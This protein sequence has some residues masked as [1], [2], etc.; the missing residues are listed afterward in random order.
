MFKDKVILDKP[1]FIGQAVLDYSK[2]EMYNLYYNIFRKCPLIR[3]PELVGGDT[4]SFF[5]A[6]HCH[7]NISLSDI[8]LSLRQFFDSSNYPSDHPLYSISN[9]AVLGCFKDEAAGKCI[10]EMILLRPKMYSMKYLGED[11]GIKRAKGISRH[12]VKSTSHQAY[13][14]A[15]HN[16]TE[17]S[18]NMTIIRSKLHTV[19]TVTF[20]KRGLSAWEDKRCWQDANSSVPHGSHLSGL[21]PKR[22]RVFLTPASGDV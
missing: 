15:Y 7:K 16:Q 11:A 17:S 14:D 22:R 13:C 21:P 12:I 1:V 8:L 19:N 2:L 18:I 5:L 6:L 4:D 9:K 20:R 3:Q 10:E